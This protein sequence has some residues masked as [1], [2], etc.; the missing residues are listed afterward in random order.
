VG[1]LTMAS[2]V[3]LAILTR[4]NVLSRSLAYSPA[5]AAALSQ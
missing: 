5:R 3:V 2:T 4:R 1:E